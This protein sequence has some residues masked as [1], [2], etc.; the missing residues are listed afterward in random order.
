MIE[1]FLDW[2]VDSEFVINPALQEAVTYAEYEI[3]MA[4]LALLAILFEV[5]KNAV[6]KQDFISN[7]WLVGVILLW[8]V[9]GSM[10]PL[11]DGIAWGTKQLDTLTRLED[12]DKTTMIRLAITKKRIELSN[13]IDSLVKE[14]GGWN[15]QVAKK[16]V[17]LWQNDFKLASSLSGARP[18]FVANPLGGLGLSLLEDVIGMFRVLLKMYYI[19]MMNIM[20]LI[21]PVAYVFSIFKPPHFLKALG[22][23]TMYG[24]VLT[25]INFVQWVVFTIF[26]GETISTDSMVDMVLSP[27]AIL[28]DLLGIFLYLKA[29]YLARLAFPI[30]SE[31]TIGPMV[32]QALGIATYGVMSKL[33]MAGAGALKSKLDAKKDGS[34]GPVSITK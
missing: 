5:I 3:V 15:L 10:K 18:E 11:L 26:I 27:G 4:S 29:F 34:Q 1:N 31:D 20:Y 6:K 19:A 16:Q 30:P 23:F 12:K 14:T 9:G 13:D 33:G 25:I 8:I 2:Y 24:L 17:Q 21:V 28:F 22:T 32:G 7:E